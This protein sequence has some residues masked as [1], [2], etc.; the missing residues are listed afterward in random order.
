MGRTDALWPPPGPRSVV[1]PLSATGEAPPC[2]SLVDHA[3]VLLSRGEITVVSCD[4]AAVTR[5][6][7]RVI[8]ALS[9]LQLVVQR[10]GGRVR[11]RAAAQSVRE[12]IALAGLES[13]LADS[14]GQAELHEQVGV[15]EVMD[16]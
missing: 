1:V 3:L 14:C 2:A 7:L 16:V 12:L 6:D 9:R 5:A 15:Q 10:L 4:L 8:D 13:V 11:L